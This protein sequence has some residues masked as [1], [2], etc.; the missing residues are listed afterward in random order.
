MKA[1]LFHVLHGTDGAAVMIMAPSCSYQFFEH[2][3]MS[4]G[5]HASYISEDFSYF[6]FVEHFRAKMRVFF[7]APQCRSPANCY[8]SF[9]VSFTLSSIIFRL[10][11][12]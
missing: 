8:S 11:C 3:S 10:G 2:T 7:F 12:A 5:L 1:F 6:T 4:I 9:V